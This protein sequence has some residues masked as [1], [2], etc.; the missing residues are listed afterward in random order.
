MQTIALM[1]NCP[2]KKK[3]IKRIEKRFKRFNLVTVSFRHK[4][5]ANFLCMDLISL[6]YRYV[7]MRLTDNGG[8]C[9]FKSDKRK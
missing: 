6:S 1:K 5:F 2:S 4:Y 3:I 9:L 7:V 8:I